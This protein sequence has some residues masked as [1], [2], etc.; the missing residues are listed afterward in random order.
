MME[1]SYQGFLEEFIFGI[2]LPE[3]ESAVSVQAP[4]FSASPMPDSPQLSTLHRYVTDPSSLPITA[5]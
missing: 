5:M 1:C 4:A 3:V 2:V